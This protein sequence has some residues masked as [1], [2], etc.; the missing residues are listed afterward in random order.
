[1]WKTSYRYAL[2]GRAVSDDIPRPA[3]ILGRYGEGYCRI[4]HFVEALDQ[5]GR[6]IDHARGFGA[7][8]PCK[9]SGARPPKLTP[10]TSRLAAFRVDPPREVCEYCWT[11]A[12]LSPF[13]TFARHWNGSRLCQG[14][15]TYPTKSVPPPPPGR[16]HSNERG[17]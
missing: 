9:G 13:G 15:A 5:R 1:M 17:N 10:V 11:E 7:T 4:C 12:P 3:T 6:I 2:R 14:V 8:D 16:D